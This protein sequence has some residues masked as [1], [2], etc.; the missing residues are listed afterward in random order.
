MGDEVKMK[1]LTENEIFIIEHALNF[2]G[3]QLETIYQQPYLGQQIASIK[4]KLNK[5][6]ND[7]EHLR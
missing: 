7:L 4:N 1:Q 3:K 5:Q 6:L 2:A